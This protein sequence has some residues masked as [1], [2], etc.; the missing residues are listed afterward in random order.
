[1]AKKRLR[2]T[3][4]ISKRDPAY[5]QER[6]Y[7]NVFSYKGEQVEVRSWTV[8]IQV[9]G[10]RKAFALNFTDRAQAAGEACHIYQTICDHGWEALNHGRGKAVSSDS[11]AASSAI[12]PASISH[13]AEYWKNRLIHRNYPEP[14]QPQKNREFSVRIEHARTTHY[15]PLGTSNENEA[16]A[17]AIR[18]YRSVLNK[19]WSHA[20]ENFP[21]ELSLALR[22][23]DNPLAWTYTTLHSRPGSTAKSVGSLAERPKS[24]RVAFVEPDAGVRSALADCAD[25]QA[26]FCCV[27]T[28][29]SAADALRE[30]PKINVEIALANHALSDEE[31]AACFEELHRRL[32]NLVVLSYSVFSDADELFKST[33]GGSTVYLLKRIAPNQLFEPIATLSGDVTQEQIATQVRNYFHQLSALLPA[34]PPFWKLAKL[35]PREQEILAL[36]AR[37]DLVKEIAGTLGISNWT[38]QGHVKSIF[39]KLKVHSRTEAVVKYLQR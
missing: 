34:G 12:S 23:Q 4:P 26:G 5:W 18:I 21:R 20:K 15:F 25:S 3:T 16:A 7:K 1:M 6:L 27:A 33:P 17:Q 38:V 8:K 39:E 11:L 32:P 28:F 13:D 9:L 22:W 24:R 14:P 2:Q 19:G 31:G 10:K 36:L 29:A 37:G 30:L 35:T